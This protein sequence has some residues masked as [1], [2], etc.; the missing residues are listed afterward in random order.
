MK[1]LS[2]PWLIRLNWD[3]LM[4]LIICVSLDLVEYLVPML[5]APFAG[6]ILDFAGVVFCVIYFGWLGFLAILELIPG[7]DTLPSF[8]ITW[9]FW[10]ILK[11]RNAR[12]RLE[13]E[14]EQWR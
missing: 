12:L 2:A 13:E 4:T 3:E 1:T 7:L 5:M 6:D 11:R 9:L 8:T 10:Y 14:L